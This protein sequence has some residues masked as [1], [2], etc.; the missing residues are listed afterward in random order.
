MECEVKYFLTIFPPSF[1]LK[2]NNNT[3]NILNI[4]SNISDRKISKGN[5]T[6]Q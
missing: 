2:M 5:L 3:N 6:G 1:A 4:V